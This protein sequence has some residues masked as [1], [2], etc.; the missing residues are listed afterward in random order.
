MTFK[1]VLAALFLVTYSAL[2]YSQNI[3]ESSRSEKAKQACESTLIEEY[4]NLGLTY[5]NPIFIRIFK[6][7]KTLEIWVQDGEEFNLFMEYDICTYGKGGH[8]PKL[9]EG[10]RMAPEGFYFVKPEQLNPWSDF[11]LAFNI[12]YPNSYDRVHKRTGSAIMVHGSC[13]SVG[14]FAMTDD[15][16]EEIYTLV[17]KSFENGQPFFRV[18]IFPF[19]MT[20]KNMLRFTTS[21]NYEFWKNLKEGYDYFE[22]NKLPP[23][24]EVRNKVYAFD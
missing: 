4:N 6:E 18:H 5:G 11:H 9:K 8:G 10:D 15:V 1:K 3:P 21:D 19:K 2:M 12:G 23:N 24:V 14:C 22:V 17:S 7:D 20:D 13:F 16:I